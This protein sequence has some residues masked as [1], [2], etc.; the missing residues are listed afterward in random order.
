[1]NT[2][3]YSIKTFWIWIENPNTNEGN[4]HFYQVM[5]QKDPTILSIAPRT[6]LCGLKVED[7]NELGDYDWMQ[8]ARDNYE[9]FEDRFCRVCMEKYK[10]SK[11]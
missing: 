5:L 8:M 11:V 2:N 4:F 3:T 9:P 1:M 6:Y 7:F 10:S